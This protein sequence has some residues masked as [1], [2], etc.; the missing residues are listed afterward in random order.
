MRKIHYFRQLARIKSSNCNIVSRPQSQ[1]R[2]KLA[3]LL[4]KKN[5]PRIIC[6]QGEFFY[7][8]KITTPLQNNVSLAAS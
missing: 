2:G 1:H 3:R 4:T 5:S 8:V 6:I 7:N